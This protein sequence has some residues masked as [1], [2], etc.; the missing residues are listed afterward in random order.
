[1]KLQARRVHPPA[2]VIGFR[3]CTTP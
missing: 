2:P 1:M 3:N